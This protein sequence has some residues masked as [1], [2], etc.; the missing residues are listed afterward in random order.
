MT[1]LSMQNIDNDDDRFLDTLLESIINEIQ[2]WNNTHEDKVTDLMQAEI[3]ERI[4]KEDGCDYEEDQLFEI[5]EWVTRL[6][7][8]ESRK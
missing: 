1:N 4:C 5:D 3:I 6:L 2:E 7:L 8:I